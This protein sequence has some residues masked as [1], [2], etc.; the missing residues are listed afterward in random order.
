MTVGKNSL[1]Q[2]NVHISS[3]NATAVSIGE[4]CYVGPNASLDSCTLMDN[5]FVGMGATVHSGATVEPFAVV[6]AGAVI[7][8]GQ[9]VPT[10]QIWAGCPAHYL[11]DITQ[12]EKHLMS[13]HKL[14]MQ[15]LS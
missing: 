11:R 3:R 13:E 12:E 6:S 14:E 8:E 7:A 9:T 15:Q 10:G 2:D 4:N 1:L 5:S